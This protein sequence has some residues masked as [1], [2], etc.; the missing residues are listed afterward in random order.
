M[1]NIDEYING[2][3]EYAEVLRIVRQHLC[4][5]FSMKYGA[6]AFYKFDPTTIHAKVKV[7]PV[8]PEIVELHFPDDAAIRKEVLKLINTDRNYEE[9]HQLKTFREKFNTTEH[10][11]FSISKKN[12]LLEH[13][14]ERINDKEWTEFINGIK[15]YNILDQLY[16]PSNESKYKAIPLPILYSPATLIVVPKDAITT[17]EQIDKIVTPVAESVHFYLFN[18]LLTEISK[19]LKPG[20]I[21][22]KPELIERFLGELSQVAIPIKY[23]CNGKEYKCFDWY[24]NWETSSSAIIEL[25]L[26]DEK[27]K[28]YMPTFCWHDNKMLHEK[29]EYKVREQQVKE[30]IQNIFGLVYNYWQTINSKKLLVQAEIAPLINELRESVAGMKAMKVQVEDKLTEQTQKVENLSKLIVELGGDTSQPFENEF[31]SITKSNGEKVW[32]IRYQGIDVILEGTDKGFE[33]LHVIMANKNEEIDVSV[34]GADG[35]YIRQGIYDTDIKETMKTY[36]EE[37]EKIEKEIKEKKFE[38]G[39]SGFKRYAAYLAGYIN[40]CKDLSPATSYTSEN[41]KLTAA[42]TQLKEWMMEK[43]FKEYEK[44]LDAVA[45]QSKPNSMTKQ[46]QDGI[47]NPIR[48]LVKRLKKEQNGILAP[49]LE[50]SVLKIGVTS[51]FKPKGELDVSWKFSESQ[52]E[53]K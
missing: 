35:A 49:L 1:S 12:D 11:D 25:T 30:T 26:A 34:L 29:D 18:R 22:D 23:E 19:D 38:G 17:L 51:S 13:S 39:E 28:M 7:F 9:F 14:K 10:F 44:Q 47:L 3:N 2:S 37:I 16:Y 42:K 31:Y 27:V 53:L 20:Q 52:N 6:I 4:S 45:K 32:K 36:K 15:K 8:N 33:G 50:A 24:G 43:A 5:A 21:K 46:Q 40:C 48:Q 41:K